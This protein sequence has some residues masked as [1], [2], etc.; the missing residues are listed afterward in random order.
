[1]KTEKFKIWT[2]ALFICEANYFMISSNQLKLLY[3]NMENLGKLIFLLHQ[4][5]STSFSN[6]CVDR[7]GFKTLHIL[8]S[9][10]ILKIQSPPPI[11]FKAKFSSDLNFYSWV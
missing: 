8:G 5:Y 9:P 3:E 2:L 10:L 7:T 1:M 11:T 6:L 4:F